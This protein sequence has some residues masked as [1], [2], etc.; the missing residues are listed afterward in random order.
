MTFMAACGGS[1]GPTSPAADG[2][3]TT[4]TGVFVTGSQSGSFEISASNA[5]ASLRFPG[6]AGIHAASGSTRSAHGTIRIAGG[7]TTSVTGTFNPATGAFTLT[8]GSITLAV[9]VD[10]NSQ[11]SGT[12][13]VSG[14]S[15]SASGIVSTSTTSAVRYCGT[16]AGSTSGRLN[17][18][19]AGAVVIGVAAENGGPGGIVL[20]GTLSGTTV[21]IHWIPDPGELGTATG[22]ISATGISNGTWSSTEGESGTWTATA[23]C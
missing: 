7:T 17:V 23:G 6:G 16:Y 21:T 3:E 20:T 12:I 5:A 15:G 19:V 22:T 18:T 10:A 8:G 1:D 13:T 4:Y 2:T 14:A 9:T 11:V